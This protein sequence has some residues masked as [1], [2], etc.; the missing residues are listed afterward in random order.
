[1]TES[2]YPDNEIPPLTYR[3]G[4]NC[5]QGQVILITGA[6]DGI[7]R[8]A[9]KAMAG[10]GASLVLLDHNVR[11]LE[12][13]YDEIEAAGGPQPALYPL[14]LEGASPDDY[15][16]LAT[17]VDDGMGKLDGLIHNAASLGRP[18]PIDHYDVEAW[19]RA[20]QANL[21]GPFMLTRA[22]LPLLRRRPHGRILFVSDAVGRRA[23]AYWGAY[24][25]SKFAVEGL[26]QTLAAELEG[27]TE[28]RV[29]SFD[30]GVVATTLRRNAYPAEDPTPLN[31]PEDVAVAFVYLM[32]P[33][34][35]ET[36]G[37]ALRMRSDTESDHSHSVQ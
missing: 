26:M 7:G 12:S 36:H 5:L 22:C 33:V 37:R 9:S 3:P 21:N 13:L 6:A 1:M 31:R 27:T 23:K 14:N 4:K 20:M 8:A 29:N 17:H 11:R 30:P 34:S 10:H 15:M 25:V 32:D 19:H 16:E 24:A 18:S 2:S 28:I 35:A